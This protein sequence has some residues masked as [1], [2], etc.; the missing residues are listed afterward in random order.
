MNGQIGKR[1]IRHVA[2]WTLMLAV[3]GCSGGAVQAPPPPV[4]VLVATVGAAPVAIADELPGRVVAYRVAEIRPQVGGIIRRLL[5]AQGSDVRAG[6]KLF[7]I[8]PAPFR[9]EAD[10]A[11]AT[12]ARAEAMLRRAQVQADRLR[13]L[14]AADAIS[15]QS[16]DDALAAQEQA[17]AD[18]TLARATLLRRRLDMG[19]ATVTSPIA[20]R[21][22]QAMVTEGALVAAGD[23]T[24]LATVQQIDR[25]YVDVRQPAGRIDALRAVAGNPVAI[26][27]A[28]GATYP[29]KGRILF[30]GI[31]VD[32]GTGD[33]I[34]RILVSNP[35]RALLPGMYVRARLPR[36]AQPGAVSIP[37]QAVGRDDA[38]NALAY[39][40]DAQGRVH[41]RAI[42]V[43]EVADGS[44]LVTGGLRTGERV[45]VEGI[46][47]VQPGIPVNT[48]PWHAPT[49]SPS[50]R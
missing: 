21:I 19:Y 47:R 42:Q 43:G 13:P 35:G 5:F 37:Q 29:V 15:R 4:E 36:A 3:T 48:A 40:V 24:A 49:A 31:S 18:R 17:A 1:G 50:R 25:V 28:T 10:S 11:A 22:D 45:I 12:L 34:V 44:Y 2:G 14:V 30:S 8:D 20:G 6:Q 32:P 46:D 33:A 16:Y 27:S 7:R 38:G 23:A 39:V 26:L 41:R 9:A